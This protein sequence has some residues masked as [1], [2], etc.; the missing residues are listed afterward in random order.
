MAHL[1]HYIDPQ[2]AQPLSQDELHPEDGVEQLKLR[3]QQL[4]GAH[5]DDV[6]CGDPMKLKLNDQVDE[7]NEPLDL[8]KK[9]DMLHIKPTSTTHLGATSWLAIMKGDPYLRVLWAHIFKVRKQA[10]EFRQ[11]KKVERHIIENGTLTPSTMS[12]RSMLSSMASGGGCPVAGSLANKGG[13]CPVSHSQSGEEN[14]APTCPVSGNTTSMGKCP[15]A[16]DL[17]Q[18][19]DIE[20]LEQGDKDERV[21]PLMI[22]DNSFLGMGNNTKRRRTKSRGDSNES[23]DSSSA[24]DANDLRRD[25]AKL[26]QRLLPEKKIIW[27]YVERFFEV[28]YIYLPYVDQ[29]EL[30]RDVLRI[31]GSADDPD[32]QVSIRISNETDFAILGNI[33]IILRLVWN[34]LPMNNSF[35]L[36]GRSPNIKSYPEDPVKI[37]LM[38]R[39]EIPLSLIEAV[40]QCFAN[41]TIM[42]K[43]S[44]KVVQCLLFLRFYFMYSPEDDDGADGVES[45]IFHGTIMQMGIS[46]GLYRDPSN[47]E[48]FANESQ[49]HL[50]RKIWYALITLD[51]SQ[52]VNLGCPSALQNHQQFS[53]TQLPTVG[54]NDFRE[55]SV[56]NNIAMQYKLDMLL[57]KTMNTLL[58]VQQPARRSDVD[59]LIK[60]LSQSINGFGELPQLGKILVNRS[61][62]EPL[63]SSATRAIHM[64]S[65]VVIN[66]LIYLLNYILYVHFEPKGS[67]NAKLATF[68]KNYAQ[69]ALD[70]AFEGYRNCT[71]FFDC[72]LDYFGPGAD[73]IL[74]PLLLLMG[75]RSMQFMVSLIL[76]SRC[77]PYM[78]PTKT[79]N[80]RVEIKDENEYSMFDVDVNSGE[81]LASVLL[82]HMDKFHILSQK[83]GQ[84]YPYSWRMGKAVGFFIILLK[85]PT[86]VVKSMVKTDNLQD[87]ENNTGDV[88]SV[89]NSVPLVLNSDEQQF[90]KC[91]M[92]NPETSATRSTARPVPIACKPAPTPTSAR[93]PTPTVKPPMKIALIPARAMDATVGTDVNASKDLMAMFSDDMDLPA[94]TDDFIENNKL[95]MFEMI[96]NEGEQFG[97]EWFN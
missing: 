37:D 28:L 84:K 4:E 82:G 83:L 36:M 63:F 59:A 7:Y 49:R 47:F 51:V 53:D 12:Q 73:L 26:M 21:C 13:R 31:I 77:G 29:S 5:A 89:L 92:F 62:N 42:R 88:S 79:S 68:A 96:L 40:K 64:R 34:T 58:N 20:D 32:Q 3:I 66:V 61:K 24:S 43:S 17:E 52:S 71:L 41:L 87:V 25:P 35:K 90:K 75:H 27:L 70:C 22:G 57:S 50:W 46:C 67:T 45:Q 8:A 2:W 38:S 11:K 48:N 1:C 18:P 80:G 14:D 60:E 23:D 6:E 74:S 72:G 54:G 65:H 33:C 76:R 19:N 85:K 91:P 55:W 16:H 78:K 81:M 9:F 39:N 97:A 56:V 93:T 15:V 95:D 44:L 69:R 94:F 10:E 30:E 86:T